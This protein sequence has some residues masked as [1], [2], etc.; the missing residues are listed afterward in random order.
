MVNLSSSVSGGRS[1]S[2]SGAGGGAGGGDGGRSRCSISSFIGLS[3]LS[4]FLFILPFF[5]SKLKAQ[6]L[7][8]SAP[9][10]ATQQQKQ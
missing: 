5:F 3:T 7:T 4:F 1:S 10:V 2:S 6:Q 8:S 9:S